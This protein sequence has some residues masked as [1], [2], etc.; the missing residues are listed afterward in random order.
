MTHSFTG[1]EATRAPADRLEKA[2]FTQG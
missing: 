2:E 1:K